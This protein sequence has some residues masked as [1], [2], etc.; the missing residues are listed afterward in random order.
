M[1]KLVVWNLMTL[2]GYFEGTGPWDLAFHLMV[3]GD[4]LEAFSLAQAEDIGT[5][6]F[7]RRTYEGMAAHWTTAEGAIA[8]FMNGVEKVVAT[9]ST[10]PLTW[11]NSRRLEGEIPA[12]VEGLKQE[13]GKDIYVFGSADLGTDLIRHRLVD[14]YRICIAPVLLGA[15][16]RLFEETGK[17]QKLELLE[18]RPLSSGCVILRYAP[19]EAEPQETA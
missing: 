13:E 18:A 5:L 14:E 10:E 3:W 9:R 16:R 15:G 4:E 8:D 17:L 12:A 1:R 19:T 2:D 11:N 6:L 7:G